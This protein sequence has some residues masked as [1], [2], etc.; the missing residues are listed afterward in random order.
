[1]IMRCSIELKKKVFRSNKGIP[2]DSLANKH[3]YGQCL[4]VRNTKRNAKMHGNTTSV[5]PLLVAWVRCLIGIAE[6]IVMMMRR[7]IMVK[8]I[9][10]MISVIMMIKMTLRI[11]II[12]IVMM[13]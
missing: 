13:M 1:M 8:V 12:I 6:M 3:C 7:R 11:I 4:E 2:E 9:M 5:C 10:V